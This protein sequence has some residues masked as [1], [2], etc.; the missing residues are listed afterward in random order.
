MLNK[1]ENVHVGEINELAE[2]IEHRALHVKALPF[3]NTFLC[4]NE[5]K[6]GNTIALMP[7]L[8]SCF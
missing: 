1:Y 6:V 8:A 7:I 2:F 4:N 5:H 3:R